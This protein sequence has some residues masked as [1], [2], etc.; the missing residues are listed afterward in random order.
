MFTL[1]SVLSL[2]EVS[3]DITQSP[4]ELLTCHGKPMILT[5][6]HM[7]VDDY[8]D[9]ANNVVDLYKSLDF[10]A[11]SDLSGCLVRFVGHDV[12]DFNPNPKP[13]EPNSHIYTWG[14]S[15]GCVNFEDPDNKGLSECVLSNSPEPSVVD[16]Y[17]SYCK[18]VSFADFIVI[19]AEALIA[20]TSN[21]PNEMREKFRKGF[22]FGRTTAK[23][24]RW[25]NKLPDPEKSCKDVEDNF[26][27]RLGL[28]WREAATLMGAHTL[29]RAKAKNSGYV[30]WWSDRLNSGKFN[31]NYYSSLLLK[32]WIPQNNPS[33]SNDQKNQWLRSDKKGNSTRPKKPWDGIN[34]EHQE[35]MLNSDMCL[36]YQP[37][38]A[39]FVK[40]DHSLHLYSNST[41]LSGGSCCA[42]V[43]ADHLLLPDDIADKGCNDVDD[44]GCDDP[45]IDP[46]PEE[47]KIRWDLPESHGI[48]VPKE[49]VRKLTGSDDGKPKRLP[50]CYN[51]EVPQGPPSN[52]DKRVSGWGASSAVIDFTRDESMFYK[53]FIE[54]WYKVTT[55]GYD[56]PYD[57]S[58]N[59][60]RTGL[61]PLDYE[62]NYE[63]NNIYL[64]FMII[65]LVST[66]ALL[67]Y[68]YKLSNKENKNIK[69]KSIKN[70]DLENELENTEV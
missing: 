42:W 3:F 16:V 56:I 29:G 10:T 61:R 6:K 70:Y 8:N 57:G 20:H 5:T 28:D 50:D 44:C 19:A 63:E 60:G 47:N 59:R 45:S 35:M 2:S 53:E 18:K 4:Y 9:I 66:I 49:E 36:V 68:L 62:Q 55:K 24:C 11:A 26:V 69:D 31:N 7:N 15:D 25:N 39:D 46:R 23:T 13:I 14:G 43:E 30:G 38:D 27:K 12:M 51:F 21:K 17:Q 67:L 41:G 58:Y 1:F 54:V 65:F 64:I 37:A 48:E 32:G 33:G 40:P 34:N 22:L 52:D